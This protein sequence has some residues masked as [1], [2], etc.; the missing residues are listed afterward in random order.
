MGEDRK[1]QNK[2]SVK[3]KVF[4]V[5]VCVLAAF[6]LAGVVY[7][8][9]YYHG[10]ETAL[11]AL[12]EDSLVSVDQTV[13]DRIVFLPDDPKAGLIFYP[14]GKVEYT[15]YAPLLRELAEEGVLCVLVKMPCNLAVLGVNAADGIQED[16]PEVTEWYIGGHSLGGSMAAVYL[17]KHT[18]DYKGL[19][20]FAAYG[21]E[22]LSQS[23]L[24]VISLYGSMDGVLNME[25]YEENREN[26][27]E[28]TLEYVIEGGNH[29][30]FGSYGSQK[31]DG[32]PAVSAEEQREAAVRLI[33]GTLGLSPVGQ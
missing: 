16:F 13:R 2:C 27:P 1:K 12:Q 14:G 23:G 20:L 11:E 26:L 8:S 17:A 10:D 31:G 33:M 9:D 15:A 24:K 19:I 21:T 28:E 7:V 25:K 30:Q 18:D 32:T 29:A 22:D 5:I 6:T 4:V 3:L